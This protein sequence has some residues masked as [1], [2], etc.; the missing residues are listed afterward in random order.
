MTLDVWGHRVTSQHCP[1]NHWCP[2]QATKAP[3]HSSHTHCHVQVRGPMWLQ[4]W[5]SPAWSTDTLRVWTTRVVAQAGAPRERCLW[6]SRSAECLVLSRG[7]GT[8]ERGLDCLQA[9]PPG[10]AALGQAL[11]AQGQEAASFSLHH[12]SSSAVPLGAVVEAPRCAAGPHA[13]APGPSAA[14]HL[15]LA[16][17]LALRR[18]PRPG[19]AAPVCGAGVQ[20]V[21]RDQR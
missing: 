9:L 21:V 14:L 18:V 13:W 4:S 2:R 6:A 19:T 17:G 16:G 15:F 11:T 12:P 10:L 8:E 7:R 1:Q 3:H 20:R 5:G